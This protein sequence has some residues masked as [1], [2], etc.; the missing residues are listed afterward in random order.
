MRTAVHHSWK[1]LKRKNAKK[2]ER[3]GRTKKRRSDVIV[4]GMMHRIDMKMALKCFLWRWN[5]V[6]HKEAGTTK[7]TT[8]QTHL[9]S[10][11][12]LSE[13]WSSALCLLR[14]KLGI[15]SPECFLSAAMNCCYN[16]TKL[17][18]QLISGV[19]QVK[20][21]YYWCL[22]KCDIKTTC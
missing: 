19:Y 6:V 7:V 22:H 21:H 4:E 3:W 12:K 5:G 2:W 17:L 15:I 18:R 16:Q 10:R 20:L 13:P 11:G 14:W 8:W 9:T 1:S